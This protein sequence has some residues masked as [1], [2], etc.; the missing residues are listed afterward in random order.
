[1]APGRQLPGACGLQPASRNPRPAT[2]YRRTQA[3]PRLHVARR[4]VTPAPTRLRRAPLRSALPRI[5][6]PAHHLHVGFGRL[7]TAPTLPGAGTPLNWKF[8]N[9]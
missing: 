7:R 3:R 6:A 1:M 2:H 5:C 9:G 4:D 8:K